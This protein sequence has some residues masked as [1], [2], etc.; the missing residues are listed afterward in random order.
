MF[1]VSSIEMQNKRNRKIQ[2][3]MEYST[4]KCTNKRE[5]RD[6]LESSVRPEKDTE[7]K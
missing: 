2:I 6:K 4:T 3:K 7:V 5:F 1:A